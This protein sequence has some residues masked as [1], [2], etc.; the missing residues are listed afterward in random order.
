MKQLLVGWIGI[1]LVVT[2]A[3]TAGPAAAV[4]DHRQALPGEAADH[5]TT[6]ASAAPSLAGLDEE[7]AGEPMRISMDFKD[8][9]LKTVLKTFSRQTG[10]HPERRRPCL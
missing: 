5:L 7:L 10:P 9:D 8:A 1:G 4:E 2:L 6:E 3:L